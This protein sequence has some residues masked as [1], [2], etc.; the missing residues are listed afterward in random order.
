MKNILF[1]LGFIHATVFAQ[2]AMPAAASSS[3]S[4]SSAPAVVSASA[5][6][7]S[8]PAA[9][10]GGRGFAAP[11]ASTITPSP[12]KF[13][14]DTGAI[15]HPGG[16]KPA[17]AATPDFPQP[18]NDTH[19]KDVPRATQ[20]GTVSVPGQPGNGWYY[21]P[22]PA[23]PKLPTLWVIGDSTVR[24]GTLGNG[25]SNFNEWGWGAP[26]VGYFDAKKINVVNRAYGGT[27]SRSFYEGFFW[28]NLQPQ[29]KKGDF[30]ILQFG[31]NDNTSASLDGTGDET[32]QATGRRGGAPTTLHT[33]GWYLKQFVTETR[34]QGGTCIICSLTPR[35]TWGADG[36]MADKNTHVDW[37]A[38][39]AQE[40]NA[41]YIDLHELIQLKFDEVGKTAVDHLYA[42][43]P[44][45]TNPRG[46]GL[47]SGWDGAVIN[48]ECVVS[49]LKALKNMPLAGFLSNKAQSVPL[50]P[51]TYV[52]ANPAPSTPAPAATT[53]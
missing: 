47:H 26:L 4:A 16:D 1:F 40:I 21:P 5:A 27:S 14:D 19:E 31:A 50:A 48:A 24:N 6:S 25:I 9:S 29:I 33:F 53:K 39:A 46:E 8:S 44:S 30:V 10:G 32:S 3:A 7:T 36:K 35:K 42:P 23:D 28:K 51:E 18:A 17:P 12:N 38:Q 45:A 13:Y 11:A 20:M 52:A 43:W 37:A 34:A 41:P 49:G 22:V 2:S 15:I